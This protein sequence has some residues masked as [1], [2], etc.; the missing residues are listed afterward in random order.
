MEEELVLFLQY[1]KQ[2]STHKE[3]GFAARALGLIVHLT[4]NVFDRFD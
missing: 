3:W 4:H 2:S 1:H